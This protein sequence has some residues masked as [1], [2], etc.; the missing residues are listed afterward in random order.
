[1]QASVILSN[2]SDKALLLEEGKFRREHEIKD[3][4]PAFSEVVK[5]SAWGR[6]AKAMS[7]LCGMNVEKDGAE[8]ETKRVRLESRM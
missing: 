6:R 8:A 7:I 4:F 1:M 2:L 5:D 3:S